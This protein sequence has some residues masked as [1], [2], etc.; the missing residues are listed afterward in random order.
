MAAFRSTYK[1]NK[2]TTGVE[3]RKEGGHGVNTHNKPFP[4]EFQPVVS[5]STHI[6]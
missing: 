5:I 3:E 1:G 6:K 4:A 2:G